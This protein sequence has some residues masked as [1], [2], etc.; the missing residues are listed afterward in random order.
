MDSLFIENKAGIYIRRPVWP[1][2]KARKFKV[3]SLG[4]GGKV[5]ELMWPLVVR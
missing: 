3:G 4:K 2:L 1:V 5:L